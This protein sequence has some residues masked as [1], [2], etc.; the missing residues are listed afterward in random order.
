M[1][2]HRC[3]TSTKALNNQEQENVLPP[4]REEDAFAPVPG[5]TSP[6]GRFLAGVE[7]ASGGVGSLDDMV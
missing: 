7:V 2:H 5:V 1:N 6:R 4:A 3:R